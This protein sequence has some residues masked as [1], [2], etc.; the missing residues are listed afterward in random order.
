M[1]HTLEHT[2]W[3]EVIIALNAFFDDPNHPTVISETVRVV[4]GWNCVSGRACRRLLHIIRDYMKKRKR[5]G[6]LT[7]HIVNVCVWVITICLLNARRVCTD[8]DTV[9]MCIDV[10]DVCVEYCEGHFTSPLRHL[11]FTGIPALTLPVDD[12][13]NHLGSTLLSTPP[14]AVVDK[15]A[16]LVESVMELFSVMTDGGQQEFRGYSIDCV[17]DL[18]DVIHILCRQDPEGATEVLQKN[19]F[20]GMLDRLINTLK[21]QNSRSGA[22]CTL[23]NIVWI[24]TKTRKEMVHTDGLDSL[25]RTEVGTGSIVEEALLDLQ[26]SQERLFSSPRQHVHPFLLVT[27]AQ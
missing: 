10:M 12:M 21:M 14:P 23:L 18:V 2:T 3:D 26:W 22:L 19:N 13:L 24:Y 7:A 4:R 9:L 11:V 20:R 1:D 25:V 6:G 27:G 15:S 8:M 16:K 5:D 17:T